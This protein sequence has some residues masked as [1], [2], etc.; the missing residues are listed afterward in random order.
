[1]KENSTRV[2]RHPAGA[3]RR[4]HQ[5]KDRPGPPKA[6]TERT[7]ARNTTGPR[8]PGGG[9]AL[10]TAA[11]QEPGSRSMR[12]ALESMRSAVKFLAAADMTQLPAETV[13]ELLAAMEPVDAGQA[14]VRGQ[15]V[16][17]LA[18]RQMY[19]EFGHR[20]PTPFLIYWTGVKGGKAAQVAKLGT[21]H[22][23]HPLLAAAL[24]E[25]D[26]VSESI[27][28]Q[29]AAWTGKL[30][31]D[32]IPA[33]DGIL[34]EACRAG[35]NEILLADLAAQ[36]RAQVCGPDPEDEGKLEERTLR[37][38]TTLDGAGRVDGNLTPACTALLKT[39]LDV[40]R[41]KDGAEDH[42]SPHERNHDALEEALKLVLA[43]KKGK[44]YKAVVHIPFAELLAM[45]GASAMIDAY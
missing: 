43:G 44:A 11:A 36:I 1:M 28:V 8:T 9:K 15:A 21:L 31:D 4:H 22:R 7:A 32:C 5:T 34:I 13:A 10:E 19:T 42:R 23:Q 3:T 38:E 29:I 37:V 14:A 20:A 26:V 2:S 33:A 24:A 25:Q 30:P 6:A 35:L 18:A 39:V 16:S 40:F 17:I 41:A 27:A 45:P 12:E